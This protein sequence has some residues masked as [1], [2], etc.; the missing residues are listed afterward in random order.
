MLLLNLAF[1]FYNLNKGSDPLSC[2]E[3]T[4]QLSRERMG[5]EIA[6]GGGGPQL[7]NPNMT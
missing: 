4:P 6:R 2:A 3:M 7:H 5:A 1:T